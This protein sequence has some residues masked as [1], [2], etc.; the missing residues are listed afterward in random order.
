MLTFRLDRRIQTGVAI[1]HI[2]K[3]F[4]RNLRDAILGHFAAVSC[5]M[6]ALSSLRFAGV[7]VAEENGSELLTLHPGLNV[8]LRLFFRDP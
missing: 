8:S 4:C 2:I 7:I 6:V 5:F 1:F 3:I